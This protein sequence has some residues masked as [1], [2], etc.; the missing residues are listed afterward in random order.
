LVEA[1]QFIEISF[2]LGSIW[3]SRSVR[4]EKLELGEGFFI[5]E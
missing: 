3:V 5:E 4:L 1:Q 2:I